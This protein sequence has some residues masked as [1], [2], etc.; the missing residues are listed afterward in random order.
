MEFSMDVAL[1]PQTELEFGNLFFAFLAFLFIFSIYGASVLY[2]INFNIISSLLFG[3]T[4]IFGM[5]F[6]FLIYY[7]IIDHPERY[8][9]G[10]L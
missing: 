7:P 9:F 3:L 4:A 5:F 10:F 8:G 1:T 6:V 2:R